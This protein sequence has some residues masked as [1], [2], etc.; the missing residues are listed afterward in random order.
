[1]ALQMNVNIPGNLT[2]NDTYVRIIN[3]MVSKKD[4]GDKWFMV[5]DLAVYVDAAERAKGELTQRMIVP[6]IDKFKFD[7]NPNKDSGNLIDVAYA[8][9]KTNKIFAGAIDV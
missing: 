5:I 7:Y 8:K 9:L 4:N 2:I 3:I 1:M 6:E